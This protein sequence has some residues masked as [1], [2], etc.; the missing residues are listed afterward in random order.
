MSRGLVQIPPTLRPGAPHSPHPSRGSASRHRGQGYGAAVV[1]VTVAVE[2]HGP[3]R[4]RPGSDRPVAAERR[5][6]LSGALDLARTL[7]PLQHGRSDPCLQITGAD[8]LRA[9]RTPEGPATTW[10]RLCGREELRV[11]AWGPGAGW[12]VDHAAVL[13]G[14]DEDHDALGALLA[15]VDQP[16][17]ALLRDVHHRHPGVR[18]PCSEAVVEALFPI[19][20]EQRVTAAGAKRSYRSLVRAHG[21][22]A[23]GPPELTGRLRLPPS[24]ARLAR[25]PSWEWHRHEVERRRGDTVRRVATHA[26]VLDAAARL[27]LTDAYRRLRSVP[28]VG[29]WT[30]GGIGGTALGDPD[31][32][33]VGDF[34]LP[35]Q[36]AWAFRGIPRSEDDEMLA[37]LEPYRGQRGRILR[38]V[39]LA[40]M[41]APRYGPR[42]VNP[43][44][45]RL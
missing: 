12:A 3:A 44:I 4:V 10:L 31:A 43:R 11:R 8:A 26:R 19:I 27:P 17:S 29:P 16:E 5:L 45:S 22:P 14:E 40:G 6:R 35:N 2:D 18:T 28:G 36:V 23:P 34:H 9:T 39:G 15:A 30:L 1:A 42:K 21:G 32:V 20:L 33:V 13:V 24:P 25:L 7:S 38:L 37:L 41:G